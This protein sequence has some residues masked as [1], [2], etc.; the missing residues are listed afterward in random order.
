MIV[1]GLRRASEGKTIHESP[2]VPRV[3][4]SGRNGKALRLHF[5][6]HMI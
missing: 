2:P 1:M 4:D 3:G 6:R 5:T